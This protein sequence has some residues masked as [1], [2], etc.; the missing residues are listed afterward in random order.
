MKHIDLFKLISTAAENPGKGIIV[1]RYDYSIV[2]VKMA[3]YGVCYPENI[4]SEEHQSWWPFGNY[5]KNQY[6]GWRE[7]FLLD[8]P[9][10]GNV[11]VTRSSEWNNAVCRANLWNEYIQ[12]ILDNELINLSD[13]LF[14]EN[15]EDEEASK[16]DYAAIRKLLEEYDKHNFEEHISDVAFFSASCK[17]EGDTNFIILGNNHGTYGIVFYRSFHGLYEIDSFL[18]FGDDEWGGYEL[19]SLGHTIALYS[20]HKTPEYK[21]GSFPF[22]NPWG[23]D[24]HYSSMSLSGGLRYDCYLPKHMAKA[25]ILQLRV[26]IDLLTDIVDKQHNHMVVTRLTYCIIAKGESEY[27]VA[28][29][30]S[31]R[32]LPFSFDKEST[33]YQVPTL[34]TELKAKKGRYD[35]AF[36]ILEPLK[37][38]G[39]GEDKRIY[40]TGYICILT[41]HKTGF[42]YNPIIVAPRHGEPICIALARAFEATQ[43]FEGL[44]DR[45]YVNRELD[46]SIARFALS[47]FISN[48]TQL[49]ATEERLKTDDAFESLNK[50]MGQ[51]NRYQA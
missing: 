1:N 6:K 2:V 29:E 5:S 12:L 41:D 44:P 33:H 22:K 8:H 26:I 14:D 34:T 19:T 38:E 31:V 49:I 51:G 9:E 15:I 36:H 4:P 7:R 17:S 3:W 46:E 42:L 20:D 10:L 25:I 32:P 13:I 50:M 43:V 35:F 11:K 18:G 39:Y 37:A 24:N 48:G 28:D 21:Y 16:E 23:K 30:I 45:I 47:A 27:F 40:S